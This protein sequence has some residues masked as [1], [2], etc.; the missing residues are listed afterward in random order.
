MPDLPDFNYICALAAI[1]LFTGIFASKIS[2]FLKVPT[3]LMFLF[4]GMLAGDQGLGGLAFGSSSDYITANLVGSAALAFILFSGGFDTRWSDVKKVVGYGT[5]LAS[6]GVLMTALFIGVFVYWLMGNPDQSLGYTLQWAMLLGCVVSST[7]AAATFA[8]FRSKGVGLKGNL[9]PLLEY[10]S[11]SNDPMAAFL[12]VFMIG[13]IGMAEPPGMSAY[14]M[15]IPSFMIKMSIGVTVGLLVGFAAVRLMDRVKL[16]FAGLYYVIGIG[17]VFA[18]F[19]LSEYTGGNGFMA[20][21]VCGMVFGNTKYIYRYS[22]ERFHDGISWLMQVAMFLMLGLLVSLEMLWDSIVYGFLIGLFIMFVARPLT[23][24]ICM[25]GSKFNYRERT[26]IAWGGIRGAAPVILAT[27]PCIHN[28]QNA[29]V[30]FHIVFF[31]VL[32]SMLVQGKTLMPVARLLGLDEPLREKAASP[33]QFEE[34]GN[35]SAEMHEYE[36]TEHSPH[37]GKALATLGFPQGVLVFLIRRN[38]QFLVPRG[39]TILEAGDE[40]LMMVERE[41]EPEVEAILAALDEV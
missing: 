22:L 23:I 17:T 21:Y 30:L 36:I 27:F 34:T 15:V 5:V 28:I 13:I 39:N 24:Y 10:E 8:I 35:A 3:L 41:M 4:M 40:M 37:C 6:L 38:N 16:E 25:L 12:T 31:I 14:L 20:S 26:L 33:L 29:D 18:A 19:S 9:R 1:F 11:G 2:D 32:S 7:D